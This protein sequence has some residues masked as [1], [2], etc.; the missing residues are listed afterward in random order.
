ASGVQREA[1]DPTELV[2]RDEVHEANIAVRREHAIPS[3]GALERSATG[4]PAGHP[5]R[6]PRM[7]NRC[8]TKRRL[9]NSIVPAPVRERLARPQAR[10]DVERLVD[11]L[12]SH[13]RVRI[14]AERRELLLTE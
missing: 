3:R 11:L 9:F 5:D 13:P 4:P 8:R 2:V 6:D 10:D 7:L 14:L 1:D 12:A